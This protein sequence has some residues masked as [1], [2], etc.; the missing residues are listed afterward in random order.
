[1]ELLINT[2]IIVLI[3]IPITLL[4]VLIFIIGPSIT[5]SKREVYYTEDLIRKLLARR[6]EGKTL[7]IKDIFTVQQASSLRT[8]FRNTSEKKIANTLAALNPQSRNKIE[9][10]VL[11]ARKNSRILIF[12]KINSKF[13]NL[14]KDL[15]P[16]SIDFYLFIISLM[17]SVTAWRIK[18]HLKGVHLL[19]PL[20]GI[21]IIDNFGRFT[22]LAV[23]ATIFFTGL[24]WVLSSSNQLDDASELF[25]KVLTYGSAAA[26][27]LTCLLALFYLIR[28][29]NP[30]QRHGNFKKTTLVL[31]VLTF[32]TLSI[33]RLDINRLVPQI[34]TGISRQDSGMFLFQIILIL[35]LPI[36][37]HALIRLFRDKTSNRYS[38]T[39]TSL[40]LLYY[41]LFLTVT[42]SFALSEIL[43]I[44]VVISLVAALLSILILISLLLVAVFCIYDAFRD[45]TLYGFNLGISGIS[46]KILI[47]I[48]TSAVLLVIKILSIPYLTFTMQFYS[49]AFYYILN[50]LSILLI[51]LILVS[52]LFL[53]RHKKFIDTTLGLQ[54]KVNYRILKNPL[55][56]KIIYKQALIQSGQLLR[57]LSAR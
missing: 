7:S 44:S 46:T 53:R 13:D 27:I 2:F 20:A 3:S 28:I 45:S 12:T 18:S 50:V 34:W 8:P 47:Y 29:T 9:K 1:M 4:I 31:Y 16:G 21:A 51:L 19:A 22:T 32:T 25:N 55:S 39:F 41:F 42:S 48:A 14:D 17:T 11:N 36:V 35:L 57:N 40:S 30:F 38:K 33:V 54:L 23:L 43:I 10:E 37:N 5:V 6:N 49:S 26:L 52:L 15:E 24:F 56:A